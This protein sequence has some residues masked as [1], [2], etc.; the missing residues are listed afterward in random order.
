MSEFRNRLILLYFLMMYIPVIFASLIYE[1]PQ[2]LFYHSDSFFVICTL[3]IIYIFYKKGVLTIGL[4]FKILLFTILLMALVFIDRLFVVLSMCGIDGVGYLQRSGIVDYNYPCFK[5]TFY[6]R[7][8]LDFLSS[9]YYP[10]YVFVFIKPFVNHIDKSI[11]E[12]RE[13]QESKNQ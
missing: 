9:L 13:E 12:I 3:Y 2:I 4:F 10:I 7:F 5:F 6:E 1:W 11:R 8:L